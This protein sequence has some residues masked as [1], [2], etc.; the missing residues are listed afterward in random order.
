MFGSNLRIGPGCKRLRPRY[1]P[2]ARLEAVEAAGHHAKAPAL[3]ESAQRATQS[4]PESIC[5]QPFT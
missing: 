4:L 1:G 5:G 2:A 3:G